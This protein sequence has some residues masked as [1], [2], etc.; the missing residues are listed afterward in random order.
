MKKLF[1]LC[2]LLCVLVVLISVTSFSVD[3]ATGGTLGSCRWRLEGETLIIDGT[4]K[5]SPPVDNPPWGTLFTE[6]KINEGITEIG[7]SAFANCESL[8]KVTLPNSLRVIRADAFF[9]C[10]SLVS[11]KIP[12][13]VTTIEG[14]VFWRC[15]S[16][17][18]V[19]ISSTV[20]YIG[21]QAFDE[22]E[23]LN[24]IFVHE[25]NTKFISVD[26]ILFTRDMS[27]LVRYPA[28]RKGFYYTVP[29]GVKELSDG[30]FESAWNLVD[31]RLPDSITKIGYN[32]FFAT[33]MYYDE[34]RYENGCLYL[35]N[36][37]VAANDKFLIDCIVKKGTKTI[38][39]GAFVMS[40]NIETVVL[41][42]G[43]THIGEN[44]FAWCY[45]LKQVHIPQSVVSVG[46][47][48][49]YECNSLETV[50]YGGGFSDRDNLVIGEIQNDPILKASWKYNVCHDGKPH[51][52]GE[53]LVSK[54]ATC[55][56]PGE[57]QRICSNCSAARSELV[58]PTG[59]TYTEWYQVKAPTC[60]EAGME[61]RTCTVCDEVKT[62][63]T[64]PTGHVFGPWT[65]D[66][67]PSCE[68]VGVEKRVCAVC[69]SAQA[70]NIEPTGHSFGEWSTNLEPTCTTEGEEHTVCPDCNTVKRRPIPVLEHSYGKGR[71]VKLPTARK[72][73]IKRFVCKDCGY[74]HDNVL[75]PVGA[76]PYI[77]A[78]CIAVPIISL[79]VVGFIILK[80]KRARS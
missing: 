31:V 27:V 13:G 78:I 39:D 49:F 51:R 33:Q 48:A 16:L 18:D 25:N 47:S 58:L 8:T 56:V 7:M 22:C 76:T 26:G 69:K 60:V 63:L 41:P 71:T 36:H 23:N 1:S 74:V 37:I 17:L 15:Y 35:G 52:F 38:A 80:K 61:E 44:A 65:V 62:K 11:I 30:A 79:A 40:T 43:F 20:N 46:E 77:V 32:A 24:N 5:L 67:Q 19:S 21:N 57:T 55:T 45:D 29:D 14:Q 12:Q 70:E 42:E 59:H 10:N 50:T 3:A 66:I 72:T 4:G 2:F 53:K 9:N 54:E 73:G 64:D 68:D 75:E 28:G 6:L 34:D